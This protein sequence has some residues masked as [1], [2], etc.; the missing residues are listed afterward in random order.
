MAKVHVLDIAFT[1]GG[2]RHAIS[3]VLIQ[4]AQDTILV[5]C[6]Y[7][8]FVPLLQAAAE[9]HGTTLATVNRL[10]VTHHDMDHI[11]SLAE[12][13]RQYPHIEIVSHESEV[14]YLNGTRQSLRLTQALASYDELPASAKEQA[15]AFM[16]LLRAVEPAGVDRIVTSGERLPWCGGVEIIHTPG[17]MPG[18]ISLYLPEQRTLIAG[19]AAVI[20]EGR[21][22]IANPHYAL[23]L[24]EAVMSVRRLLDYEIEELICYHGGRFE[25]N[26]R[27]ALLQLVDAYSIDYDEQQ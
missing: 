2:E 24:A 9:Q 22:A 11:G 3:P 27:E 7:P 21:L 20:E 15:E 10:I 23:D 14:P 13:K 16:N 18:H 25:G 19:D 8:E 17:H 6:G 5:D 4:D 12:L 1:H 26:I